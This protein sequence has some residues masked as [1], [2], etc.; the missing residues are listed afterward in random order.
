MSKPKGF[1]DLTKDELIRSAVEDFAIDLSEE[2]ASNKRA[3]LA[4]FLENSLVWE[5]YVAQ[6]PEVAPE[7]VVVETP[8]QSITSNAPSHGVIG[9]DTTTGYLSGGPNEEQV[10]VVAPVAVDEPV[11]PAVPD[12]KMILKMT[13]ENPLYQTCGYTFTDEH[14]Y[15][16]T[17][18]RDAMWILE[19]EEGF[20]Q[21]YPQELIEF[22]G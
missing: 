3:V 8:V 12:G 2:E 10:V 9:E 4:A 14:P 17:T 11:I 19:H 16:L 6:H 15:A 18:A 1:K 7:P 13:R 22:Y 5:D 21:A 20:R